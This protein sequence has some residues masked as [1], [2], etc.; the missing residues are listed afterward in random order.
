M[1][2]D[3]I[4]KFE[5]VYCSKNEVQWLLRKLIGMPVLQEQGAM[6]A[7]LL[8]NLLATPVTLCNAA[9]ARC[10]GCCAS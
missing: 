2:H 6:A 10:S 3:L 7:G 5:S 8:L 9:R 1:L 4:I